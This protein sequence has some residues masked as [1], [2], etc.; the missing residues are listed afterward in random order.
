MKK[1]L[2]NSLRT[3][4]LSLAVLLSLPMLAEE[5]MIDGLRYELFTKTKQATV[6][7][8]IVQ[9]YSG[10]IIIPA[11][12]EYDGTNYSVTSIGSDAFSGCP[13]LTS[14]NIPNSVTSIGDGA[15]Y[16]CSGL[17]SVTIGN[18]VDY[19][20][21]SAFFRCNRLAIVLNL[22]DL[23]IS[24]GSKS[25]GYVAYYAERVYNADEM[26]G[27]YAFKESDGKNYLVR[28]VGDDKS[29]TLPENYKENNYNI[30]DEAFYGC[31]FLT[32]IVIPNSVQ[33]IGN[34]AFY[35]CKLSSLA[36]G[37]GVRSIG[38]S[39]SESNKPKKVFWL[40]SRCPDGYKNL[41]GE[42][43]YVPNDQYYVSNRKIYP[44][45]PPY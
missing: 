15:F 30:G 21:S 17:T 33:V 31:G 35:G 16:G 27:D 23:D 12:V 8:K 24:R 45:T 10:K 26:V 3:L 42:L 40:P 39:S 43:N 25:H 1:H 18:S 41:D 20:G 44:Y 5:I 34:D 4:F 38:S 29:I 2:P 7:R 19:I 37:T 22:S 14:V 28:Y 36:I 11:S 13:E 32:S 9:D 6:I